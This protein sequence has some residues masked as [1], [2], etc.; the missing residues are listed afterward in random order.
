MGVQLIHSL[1]DV[2]RQEEDGEATHSLDGR[3]DR[4]RMQR[5]LV[6]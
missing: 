6:A 2:G 5:P 4:R 1:D 3:E